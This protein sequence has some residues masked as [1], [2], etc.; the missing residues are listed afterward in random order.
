MRTELIHFRQ[1]A[2]ARRAAPGSVPGAL[3]DGSVICAVDNYPDAL[4]DGD[5]LDRLRGLFPG[6][7]MVRVDFA[8]L[9]EPRNENCCGACGG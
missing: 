7:G 1:D 2:P 5:L 3:A 6:A 4:A 8:D 9:P